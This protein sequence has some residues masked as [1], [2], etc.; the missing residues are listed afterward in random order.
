MHSL[1]LLSLRYGTKHLRCRRLEHHNKYKYILS[2]I[3]VQQ[4]TSIYLILY[5]LGRER[6]KRG[7]AVNGKLYVLFI[8]SIRIR[9]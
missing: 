8:M 9:S 6:C 2:V 7:P 3:P 5:I 1:D 4:V